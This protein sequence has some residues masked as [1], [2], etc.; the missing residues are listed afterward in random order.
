MTLLDIS[1]CLLCAVAI[2]SGQLL[3][4]LASNRLVAGAA[5]TD[6][7][8][9]L[10]LGTSFAIYALASVYWMW[11]LRKIPLSQAYTLLATTYAIVPLCAALFFGETIRPL[12]WLGVG[13]IGLGV[14]LTVQ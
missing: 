14:W 1:L 9:L 6:I 3:F 11:L 4:K 12:F 8:F 13:L 5:Y 10:I 2:S 7:G